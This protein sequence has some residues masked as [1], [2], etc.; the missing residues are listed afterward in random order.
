M[1]SGLYLTPE[2]LNQIMLHIESCQ[3]EEGC[4]LV[5]GIGGVSR[6]VIPVEND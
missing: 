4:G 6:L 3:P 5:G 1:R 2:H